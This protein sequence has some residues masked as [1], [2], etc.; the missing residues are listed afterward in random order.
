MIL[1]RLERLQTGDSKVNQL[2][3]N[4]IDGD[5]KDNFLDVPTDCPQRDERLGWTGDA[6]IFQNSMLQYVYAAFI[7]IFVG[8]ACRQSVL[9]G[10]VP[11]VVPR[12]KDG[13]GIRTWFVPVG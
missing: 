3:S 7:G 9:E 4:A 2:F 11:N 12:L 6:Q 13:N 5:S 8:Y 10:S 1:N